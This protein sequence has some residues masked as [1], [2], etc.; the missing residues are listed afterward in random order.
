MHSATTT[1]RLNGK[2][3]LHTDR[4]ICYKCLLQLVA[5]C[6]Q[7]VCYSTLAR[8]QRARPNQGLGASGLRGPNPKSNLSIYISSHKGIENL[9]CQYVVTIYCQYVVTI[10]GDTVEHYAQYMSYKLTIPGIDTNRK[11]IV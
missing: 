7:K 4:A 2:A 8:A 1:R 5:R 3:A 9:Y 10:Y 11:K 6:D